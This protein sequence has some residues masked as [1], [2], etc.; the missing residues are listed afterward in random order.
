V[1]DHGRGAHRGPVERE[2]AR[3]VLEE[4]DAVLRR[5]EGEVLVVGGAHVRSAKAAVQRVAAR[6]AVEVAQPHP[7]GE[8]VGERL[9]HVLLRH[10][11]LL[12]RGHAVLLC[13]GPA[14]QVQS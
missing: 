5:L 13:V 10:L 9:V 6:V 7:H 11:P 8:E 4:D 3:V 12:D 14:V 2:D 1:P